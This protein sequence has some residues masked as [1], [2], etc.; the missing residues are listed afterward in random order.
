MEVED[1]VGFNLVGENNEFIYIQDRLSEDDISKI[2][3]V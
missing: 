2:F 3:G 1:E